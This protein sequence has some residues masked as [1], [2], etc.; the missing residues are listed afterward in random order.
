M[1]RKLAIALIAAVT[2][3]ACAPAPSAGGPAPASAAP[4]ASA[5]VAP[6]VSIKINW[7]AVSGASSGLWTAFEAGYFKD[8]NITAELVNIASSSRAVAA[9]LSKEVQF[10][11]LDGQVIVDANSQ[12]AGL[13][14]I[15]GINNRLVFSVMTKPEITKPA[16]LKGKKLGITTIGSSTHTAGLLALRTWGMTVSDVTLI[17]LNEVPNI[18]TGLVAGQV[19]AGVVSPPTNTRAKAAGFRELIN[20]ATDGPEWPSVAVGAT[21]EYLKANPT[22]GV[23]FVRAYARGVQRFKSDK[24]F[25]I[26]VLQ[27]YLKID[28]QAILEDTWTQYS[29]YLAEVP[30]VLGMQNTLDVVAATNDKA[31]TMKPDDLIDST[32]VK[33]LDD[34]GFFKKLYG[35]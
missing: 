25:A 17:Q 10:T 18:L 29:K 5:T 32:Y 7:T 21:A 1:M 14:L 2:A 26:T 28:D 33:Q 27:K 16:D 30:Y 24:A 34:E 8:E 22:V 9:L 19:D 12:G 6:P 4:S 11:H 23:R 35:R 13:K 15:Y 31:K 20:L 3:A